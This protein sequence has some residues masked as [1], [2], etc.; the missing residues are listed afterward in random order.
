MNTYNIG[1]YSRADY[2]GVIDK[3]FKP[4]NPVELAKWT[5]SIVGD[6]DKRRYKNFYCTG[7]YSGISTGYTVGC[8][9]RC[10]FCWVDLN[11]DFPFD[12]GRYYSPKEVFELLIYNAKKSGVRNLR[13]SGGEPTLCREHLLSL[14]E[15]VSTTDYTFIL[16]TNGI[17]FGYDEMYVRELKKIKQVHIRVSLKAGNGEGFEQRTGAQKKFFGLPF[18]A[19]KNLTRH[20]IRFHVACM[21]DERLMPKEE[22]KDLLQRLSQ[23]EYNGYLEEERCDP[24]DTT[25]IR[26]QKAGY[27]LF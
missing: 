16:E 12:S 20:K 15:L 26:L 23:I 24:Y 7:V 9:L 14:L 4:F 22:K 19:I 3:N 17:L 27:K 2:P 1:S 5:E 6:G 10:I 25:I 13:I 21:S 8:C 11:R 18:Q